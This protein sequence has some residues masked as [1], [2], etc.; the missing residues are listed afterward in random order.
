MKK[1]I[2][3]CAVLFAVAVLSATAEYYYRGLGAANV[4]YI[5]TTKDTTLE[6]VYNDDLRAMK[7]LANASN[8]FFPHP[9]P[10]NSKLSKQQSSLLWKALGQYNYVAGEIYRVSFNEES[11]IR[12]IFI[13][14]VQIKADGSCTWMGFTYD[15]PY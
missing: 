14:T 11:A 13:L 3:A 2:A 10:F 15:M 5:G 12:H 6:K 9:R 1:K 4:E 7:N 8:G